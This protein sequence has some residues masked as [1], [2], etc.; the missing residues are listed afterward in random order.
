MRMM[1]SGVL[2]AMT[3]GLL[4]AGL[5]GGASAQSP[6]PA[7]MTGG[8]D[9]TDWL[10]SAVGT[11]PVA[12]GVNANLVFVSGDAG[13]FAGCNSFFASY[14]SD[15]VS[16]LTFGDIATTLKTCDDATNTFEASYLAALATV[17]TYKETASG[18]DMADATGTTVLSYAATAPA[19][20]EGPWIVT[21]Y[22]NGKGGV[23]SVSADFAPSVAFGPDGTVEGFGGC[24]NF[25]GGYSVNGAAIA[26]GPLMSTMKSCGDTIDAQ[27]TAYLTALQTATTWAVTTGTLD[28]RDAGG[29]QQ[30]EAS[31]AIGH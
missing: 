21:N 12:S 9:G 5:A 10:L 11:S 7:A 4:M 3:T 8:L 14:T 18:L 20:V 19:T 13:G 2:A 25:S 31:S 30:V 6:S 29:A 23:E 27:E 26:I 28:L 16:T 17:A 1:R 15:G 22:N 24:N